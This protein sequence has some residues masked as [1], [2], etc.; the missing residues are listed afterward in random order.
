[1]TLENKDIFPLINSFFYYQ[2]AF[3]P[4][5]YQKI[6]KSLFGDNWSAPHKKKQTN[7]K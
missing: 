2:E 4:A 1:M 5:N 7:L 6:L 3:L